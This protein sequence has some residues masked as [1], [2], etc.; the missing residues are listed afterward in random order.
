[1]SFNGNYSVTL[2]PT[3]LGFILTDTSSGSDP[4]LTDRRVTLYLSDGT[5]LVP[6]NNGTPYIDWPIGNGPL[7]ISLLTKD[8]SININVQWISS[9]PL[10]SPSTYTLSQLYTF[11]G[12]LQQFDYGL[13]QMMAANKLLAQDGNFLNNKE[14][15]QLYIENAINATLYNDQFNAQDNLNAAYELQLN[16]NV[17][18]N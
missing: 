6:L 11:T 1:M 16:Q 15:L 7:T 14:L 9:A 8:Y 3:P 17:N 13:T 12:N 5:T 18:F 2:G 10:S 4:N